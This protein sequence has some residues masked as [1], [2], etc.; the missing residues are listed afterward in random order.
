[1]RLVGWLMLCQQ[2]QAPCGSCDKARL[3]GE[4][5]GPRSAGIRGGSFH[6]VTINSCWGPPGI[7]VEVCC[8]RGGRPTRRGVVG[9]K[10]NEGAQLDPS[11]M[12]GG[13][14]GRRGGVAI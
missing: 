9:V 13:G 6:A 5:R 11:Q 10:Y 8:G 1:M 3:E 7:P 14:G 12:G 4:T 2:I